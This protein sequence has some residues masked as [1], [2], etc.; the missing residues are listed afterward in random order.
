MCLAELVKAGSPFNSS[1]LGTS[2]WLT[3]FYTDA[4]AFSFRLGVFV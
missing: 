1:V 4:K 2:I 3:P